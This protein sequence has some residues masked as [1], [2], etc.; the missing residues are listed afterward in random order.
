[1]RVTNL[2]CFEFDSWQQVTTAMTNAAS[3]SNISSL[4]V[5][6]NKPILLTSDLDIVSV[7]NKNPASV[8]YNRMSINIY[9]VQG[10]DPFNWRNEPTGV[11]DLELIIKAST[12]T[13]YTGQSDENNC[14]EE[15]VQQRQRING[16]IFSFFNT[17]SFL[18]MCRYEQPVCPFLFINATIDIFNLTGL[19]NSLFVTNLFTFQWIPYSNKSYLNSTVRCLSLR[20][21]NYKLDET[22]AHPLV[23]IEMST[24]WIEG[25]VSVIQPDIFKS[26]NSLA[27]IMFQVFSL[28]NFFHQVGLAWT[29][30]LTKIA[31]QLTIT[32]KDAGA[33]SFY[34]GNHTQPV[35]YPGVYTYP[36]SDLCLFALTP[37][38]QIQ[39]TL[40]QS[41]GVCSTTI[42]WLSM[43]SNTSWHVLCLN[44]N[45]MNRALIEAKANNCL[46]M[47]INESKLKDYHVY[48]DYYEVKYTLEFATDLFNFIL[49]PFVCIAGLLLN[50]RVI[51]TV[52]K[53]SKEELKENFYQ[54]MSLNSKFN[55]LY[56]LIYSF[57]PINYCFNHAMSY[58]C[59][60]IYNKLTAQVF[61]KIIL[62]T[63]LGEAIKM[64]SNISFIFITINRYMLVGKDHSFLLERL[65]KWE[66]NRVIIVTVLL[67]FLANIGHCFQYRINFGWGLEEKEYLYAD[68]NLD[69]T[70]QALTRY[71]EL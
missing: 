57:Y 55:C 10:L 7:I 63:Y 52:R 36:D 21:Y 43:N 8:P 33:C 51:W 15:F 6:L 46:E 3:T 64:C 56:C 70:F 62:T 34:G 53:N 16:T 23:F 4:Y 58:F 22:I 30:C 50:L 35:V 28:K 25:T 27:T 5:K 39:L 54:Y 13:F 17:F 24:V 61:F 38:S 41:F 47:Q 2:Y 69:I 9:G 12:V 59:S 40:D 14:T 29:L 20:G 11:Y 66:I 68:V 60:I 18:D 48:L 31:E 32:F 44:Q 37:L 71:R 67:S 49:I 1:L 19:A 26:F 45:N 65:S 42:A